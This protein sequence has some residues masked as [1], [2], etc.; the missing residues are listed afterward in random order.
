M[1]PTQQKQ[2]GVPL[3][4]AP[5]LTWTVLLLMLLLREATPLLALLPT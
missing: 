2:P 3:E 4:A 1:Q 5:I